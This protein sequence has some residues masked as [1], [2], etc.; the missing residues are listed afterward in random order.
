MEVV[1]GWFELC[2][3]LVRSVVRCLSMIPT[4]CQDHRA[5]P[6]AGE[7]GP[8]NALKLVA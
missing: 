1:R 5:G 4:Q 8:S 2:W 6:K 7:K 3:R